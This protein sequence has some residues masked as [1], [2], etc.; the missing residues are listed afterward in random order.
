MQDQIR[1]EG[2]PLSKEGEMGGQ[3]EGEMGGQRER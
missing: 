3:R 1:F 2:D